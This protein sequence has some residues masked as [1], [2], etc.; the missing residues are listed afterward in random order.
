MAKYF[1]K[2]TEI[3]L[4]KEAKNVFSSRLRD[5]RLPAGK[6]HKSRI[7]IRNKL[8]TQITKSERMA[9]K[10]IATKSTLA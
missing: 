7:Q 8:A 9:K 2:E 5:T 1:D 4:G 3:S 10:N 6:L